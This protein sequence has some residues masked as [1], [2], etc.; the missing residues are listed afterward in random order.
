MMMLV[1]IMMTMNKYDDYEYDSM[2]NIVA[3]IMMVFIVMKIQMGWENM[4][5]MTYSSL[6]FFCVTISKGPK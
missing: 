3:K 5:R 1:K 4:M 6:S 2:E